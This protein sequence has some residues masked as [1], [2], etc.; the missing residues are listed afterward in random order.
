MRGLAPGH[1]WALLSF[2]WHLFRC[3]CNRFHQLTVQTCV[4]YS[5]QD[6]H[7]AWGGSVYQRRLGRCTTPIATITF[8]FS[9][10]PLKAP[11]PAPALKPPSA[12]VCSFF[13][14]FGSGQPAAW[15]PLVAPF[16]V[17]MVWGS[18][19]SDLIQL[20]HVLRWAQLPVT[21]FAPLF[22]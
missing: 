22:P 3:I 6:D 10:Q 14:G 2:G 21:G 18:C 8:F 5:L 19:A 20:V 16:L 17:A 12:L 15:R 11:L 9:S 13:L 4:P 1:I 7:P